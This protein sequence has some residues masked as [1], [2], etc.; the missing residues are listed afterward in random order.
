MDEFCFCTTFLT[1]FYANVTD[2]VGEIKHIYIF[3]FCKR[4]SDI[5]SL[6]ASRKFNFANDSVLFSP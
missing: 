5:K 4:Y 2:I 3:S 1:F 6:N